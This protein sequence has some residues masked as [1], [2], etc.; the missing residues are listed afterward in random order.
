MANYQSTHTGAEI[1]AGIDLLDNNSATSGQVLTA[2]GTGG[3]SWQ[4]AIGGTEVVANP[5]GEATEELTKLQVGSSV[6]SIPTGGTGGGT[7]LY[8]HRVVISQG[9]MLF[10]INREGSIYNTFY[11][12]INGLI[13]ALSIYYYKGD[14]D[15]YHN[16]LYSIYIGEFDTNQNFYINDNGTLKELNIAGFTSDSVTLL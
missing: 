5:T 12:V 3:A 16:I 14:T 1:D 6:Y 9:N 11:N 10:I 8:L 4:D 13:G 15:T 2:N 7:Q